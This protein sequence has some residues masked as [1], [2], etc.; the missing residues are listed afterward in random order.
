MIGFTLTPHSPWPLDVVVG[1]IPEFLSEADPRPANE[2]IDENYIGGWS[3]FK[4]FKLA[5][6]DHSLAYPGDPKILPYAEAR[7]RDEL[8]LV[9]PGAWVAVVQP[10]GNYEIARL[11]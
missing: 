1:F 9:Y 2:Q 11:D 7:L 3:A 4:G 10:N 5:H 8:I 6:K